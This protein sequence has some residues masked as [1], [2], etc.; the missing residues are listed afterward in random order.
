MLTLSRKRHESIMI[1]DS[2]VVTI[3]DICGDKVRIGI[4]A[5][6]SVSVLRDE[7]EPFNPALDPLRRKPSNDGNGSR[8]GVSQ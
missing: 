5:P 6:K 1:G 4:E 2:I 7:L 3:V 8:G